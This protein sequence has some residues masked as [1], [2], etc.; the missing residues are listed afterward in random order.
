MEFYRTSSGIIKFKD[1]VCIPQKEELKQMILFEVH[2]SKLS[3]HPGSTKIYQDLRKYFWWNGMKEDIAKYVS[4]CLTCRKSKVEHHCTPGTLQ[5]LE[6][7]KWKW[8]NI[9]MDFISGLPKTRQNFDAICVIFDRLT[10]TAHF[11]PIK[12]KYKLEKLV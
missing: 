8:D 12:M 4:K 6:I 9:S 11:L 1:T 3:F 7:P 10:N 2:K 5:S